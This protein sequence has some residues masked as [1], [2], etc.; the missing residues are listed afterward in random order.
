[1]KEDKKTLKTVLFREGRLFVI[2]DSKK[3]R[4]EYYLSRFLESG[5]GKLW[6]NHYDIDIN[7]KTPSE[8]PD[9]I[10]H[11]HNGRK[12]GL[13]LTQFV[14]KDNNGNQKGHTENIKA[15]IGA[16]SKVVKYFYKTKNIPLSLLID[17]YDERKWTANWAEHLE[18]CYNPTTPIFNIDFNE[19][20]KQI[21]TN[22]EETGVPDCGLKKTY[23]TINGY[24]FIVSFSKFYKPYTSVCVN[25]VS[26]YTED[27]FE[28]L[29]QNINKKNI[30]YPFYLKNCD[31]CHL[32]VISEGSSTG[33]TVLFSDKFFNMKFKSSFPAVYLIDFG[34]NFDMNVHI[35]HIE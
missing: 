10:F 23:I 5:Q 19:F 15:L 20:K 1:M 32:L 6:I 25:N 16:A 28:L 17:Y 26:L 13:E 2:E 33:N 4:E 12:V 22:I 30:K 18:Y 35:L 8:S 31:D 34:S 29:N 9:F 24:S 21:I 14:F 3:G 11:T 7:S 27:P